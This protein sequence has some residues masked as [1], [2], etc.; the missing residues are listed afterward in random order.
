MMGFPPQRK[1]VDRALV[2]ASQEA[3][4]LRQEVK[5]KE[6]QICDLQA[7]LGAQR[8]RMTELEAEVKQVLVQGQALAHKLE[9]EV[10]DLEASHTL[11]HHK[12]DSRDA[13]ISRL[14]EE[15]RVL[16]EGL[17]KGLL[18]ASNENLALRESD[19]ILRQRLGDVLDELTARNQQVQ[20]GK[21]GFNPSS[22]RRCEVRTAA[23]AAPASSM[24]LGRGPVQTQGGLTPQSSVHSSFHTPAY[25]QTDRRLPSRKPHSAT[26]H[27]PPAEGA[28]IRPA[29]R[30]CSHNPTA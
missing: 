22:R 21:N 26:S 16:V 11:C 13:E 27:I 6:D 8:K 3:S 15:Q 2:A 19:A 4:A 20:H 18:Q 14:K 25:T 17:E 29:Q 12:I 1:D 30:A 7:S 10:K 24:A 9:K 5:K 28:P 23:A